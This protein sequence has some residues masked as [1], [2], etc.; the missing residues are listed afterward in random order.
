MRARFAENLRRSKLEHQ[1][2][3]TLFSNEYPAAIRELAAN[4]FRSRAKA[5]SESLKQAI[6][7]GWRPTESELD[8]AFTACLNATDYR[9]DSH[10]DIKSAINAFTSELGRP[11]DNK[12][13]TEYALHIGEA[14]V[15]SSKQY[16]AGIKMHLRTVTSREQRAAASRTTFPQ[17]GST[18]EID[19]VGTR[20]IEHLERVGA[21]MPSVKRIADAL[22]LP[23]EIVADSITLL[24]ARGLLFVTRPE[25]LPVV[26]GRF[27]LSDRARAILAQR[28]QDERFKSEQI[29]KISGL[30]KRLIQS[31]LRADE[32]KLRNKVRGVVA[33]CASR[34]IGASGAMIEA[35]EMVIV[36][37]IRARTER[38]ID[39][40]RQSA[41]PSKTVIN[42]KD[43]SVIFD[44]VIDDICHDGEVLLA[45]AIKATGIPNVVDARINALRLLKDELRERSHA[46]LQ[47]FMES[48]K[49]VN[50]K[51]VEKNARV[52]SNKVFITHGRDTERR[53]EVADFIRE[54]GLEPVILEKQP[55][56]GLTIIEKYEKYASDVAF[57]I[58]I[59]TPDDVGCLAADA[60]AGLQKRARQNVIFELGYMYAHIRRHRVAVL[61]TDPDIEQPSNLRGIG[62]YFLDSNGGWRYDLLRELRAAGILLMH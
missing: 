21:E 25:G 24:D 42:E 9:E 26:H 58:A 35:V 53:S 3:G 8:R 28:R 59:L 19:E 17:N 2:A 13:E 50:A 40:I 14:Q 43:I 1:K 60:P 44:S 5:A 39:R 22:Q 36:E 34:G 27:D 18:Q 4:E 12:T 41:A 37:S 49:A 52:V 7:A 61:I 45:D 32:P 15:Q 62:W 38:A 56:G 57:G 47:V 11:A 51:E 30:A 29:D 33:E 46:E 10:S 23:E 54:Q 6:D 55:H 16:R 31:D 48:S 20:I